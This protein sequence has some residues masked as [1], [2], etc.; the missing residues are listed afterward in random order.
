MDNKMLKYGSDW[1]ILFGIFLVYS[2]NTTI[3]NYFVD[4]L[5]K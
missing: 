4:I 1:W 2:Y 3:L 5:D